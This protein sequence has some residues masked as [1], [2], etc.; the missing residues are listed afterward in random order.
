M[1]LRIRRG[2]FPITVNSGRV[3]LTRLSY[4]AMAVEAGLFA[5]EISRN[6]GTDFYTLNE[7]TILPG[8]QYPPIPSED[9]EALDDLDR[10]AF[11]RKVDQTLQTKEK[12]NL[13]GLKAQLLRS[14]QEARQRALG[15]EMAVH[16][17]QE[18]KAIPNLVHIVSSMQTDN[19]GIDCEEWGQLV[20][21]HAREHLSC[22]ETALNV[23]VVHE[24]LRKGKSL[25]LLCLPGEKE[26]ITGRIKAKFETIQL[27]YFY[28]RPDPFVNDKEFPEGTVIDY[29]KL[30]P[31]F[32]GCRTVLI[33]SGVAAEYDYLLRMLPS[34]RWVE[35][36]N[37]L[38]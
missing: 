3:M 36:G 21:Q 25:P 16:H 32:K 10:E 28:I 29:E 17:G 18:R 9:L 14:I 34:V 26:E 5:Q 6:V 2:D 13:L 24:Q 23:T 37:L 22:L 33:S 30:W 38:T 35:V 11:R 27:D 4:L 1:P 15:L 31:W 12:V 8:D 20:V 7:D 19:P